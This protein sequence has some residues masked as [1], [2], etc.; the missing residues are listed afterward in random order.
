MP[1]VGEEPMGESGGA[2]RIPSTGELEMIGVR[3]AF[4]EMR[5]AL[6]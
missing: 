2:D 3:E 6:G 1:E 4:R 5:G